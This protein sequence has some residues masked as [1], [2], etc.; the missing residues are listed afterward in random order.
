[1]KT[2][3]EQYQRLE[4]TLG[5]FTDL[6]RHAVEAHEFSSAARS[7]LYLLLGSVG[8]P[9]GALLGCDAGGR[10]YPAAVKGMPPGS[11][12][13][14]EAAEL[15]APFR[16]DIEELA[17]C[18]AWMP[19]GDRRLPAPLRALAAEWGMA[20]ILP[21]V[22]HGQLA[23]ALLAGTRLNGRPPGEHERGALET[24]GPY[25]AMLLQQHALVEQLR[26]AV[27][28]NLRLCESLADTYFDTV[29]AFSA[30]I[31]A[32]DIYTRGHSLRVARYSSGMA[33]RLGMQEKSSTG[34]RI[35]A[36]LHDIGKI[37]LDR[38]LLNKAGTLDPKERREMASHPLV[39]DQV[40]SAVH[41]P[42]PEVRAV[43]RSH[44]ERMDGKGYPDGLTG[45][46]IPLPA[47]ILTVADAFDAMTSERAYREP[48]PPH[49]ALRELVQCSGEQFDPGLVRAFLEQCRSEVEQAGGDGTPRKPGGLRVFTKLL[50]RTGDSLTTSTID[51]LLRILGPVPIPH[52]A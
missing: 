6:G 17:R 42:W 22:V 27:Q 32:K 28:E 31:D 13:E 34:I 45:A 51:R 40:L 4:F 19:P 10:L 41:F 44:H 5:A 14:M 8:V 7:I 29:Q 21:L 38:T 37:V 18:P 20:G 23:G 9:R 52:P 3:S 36:Y 11:L 35:G 43:V 47:R 26:A 46:A 30:A 2:R 50:R 48:V 25:A 12:R 15:R 1:V 24:L 49:D 16:A 39:G 33:A